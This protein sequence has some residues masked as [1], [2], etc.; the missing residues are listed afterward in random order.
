L[1]E[2]SIGLIATAVFA[3]TGVLAVSEKGI[4]IFGAIVL[5]IV[6]AVGGGTIR[7]LILGVKVFYADDP[8]YI[9]VAIVSALLAFSLPS[10]FSRTQQLLL[11]LD[12]FGC[13]LFAIQAANKTLALKF[14]IPVM[15]VMLAVITAIGG[16]LF[17]DVLAGRT[18]LLMTRQLY[19]TPILLGTI[20]Y[21]LL[22]DVFPAEKYVE[23]ACIG[24]IFLLRS[25]AIKW[26]LQMPDLLFLKHPR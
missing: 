16:G 22:L 14:G 17:R 3:I 1:S 6:T 19:A 25:A 10:L 2:Y 5:A 11:Y 9:W 7:D 8:T 21:V 20:L 12:G 13:A 18:N 15:P 26:D 23:M 4:D 24:I